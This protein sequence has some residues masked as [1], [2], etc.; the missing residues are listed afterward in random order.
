MRRGPVLIAAIAVAA[1]VAGLIALFYLLPSAPPPPPPCASG[2][3]NYAFTPKEQGVCI[4]VLDNQAARDLSVATIRTETNEYNHSIIWIAWR[5]ETTVTYNGTMRIALFYSNGTQVNST[6]FA[7]GWS[8]R[9]LPGDGVGNEIAYDVAVR[10]GPF[11]PATLT[12]MHIFYI[13][14]GDPS[15][16]ASSV[17]EVVSTN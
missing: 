1:A 6:S 7:F 16:V 8:G 15:Y 17:V 11:D 3:E 13:K 5:S 4:K 14:E 9:L 10:E 12:K 2:Y